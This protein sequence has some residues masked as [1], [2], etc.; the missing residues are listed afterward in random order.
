MKKAQ[1][2]E[3]TKIEEEVFEII[4]D[5]CGRIHK[6][7]DLPNKWHNISMHHNEWGNDSVDSYEVFDVCSP[8]CYAIQFKDC[9]IEYKHKYSAEIDGFEIQFARL[10]ANKL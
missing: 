9:V 10:F 1:Q 4:C 5:V 2:K 7:M 3:V 8:E 6:G